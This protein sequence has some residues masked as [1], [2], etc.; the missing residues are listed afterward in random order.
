VQY[1]TCAT[2]G[3]D[4]SMNDGFNEFGFQGAI[5]PTNPAW[6]GPPVRPGFAHFALR[7]A[8]GW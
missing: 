2:Q 1:G 7:D 4:D 5:S 3:T 8:C 6:H